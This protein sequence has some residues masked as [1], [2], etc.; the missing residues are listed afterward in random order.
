[1][2]LR[3]WLN[4]K[5]YIKLVEK[6]RE[7]FLDGEYEDALVFYKKAFEYGF[8]IE[9][10][11]A[12]GFIYIELGKLLL[13]EEVFNTVL[14]KKGNSNALYGLGCIA[15]KTGKFEEAIK[16][17]EDSIRLNDS[18]PGVYFDCAYLYDELMKFDKAKEYYLKVIELEDNNFWAHLNIGTI[19]E[20]ENDLVNSLSHYE[21]AYQINNTL[22]M[23]CYNLGV[24]HSKLGNIDLAIRYYKEEVEK[25]D[26]YKNAYFNL[27][28]LYKDHLKDYQLAKEA[29]LKGIEDDKEH[30]PI[31][32]NLGCLYALLKDY[33]NAFDCFLY[34]K[35][36]SPKLFNYINED[37][38]LFEFRKSQEYNDLMK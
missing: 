8:Y 14:E 19:Y 16:L 28:I 17:Y 35:Y 10:L 37:E 18:V 33:K 25:K 5:K 23:I 12:L 24:V 20:Q 11:N 2:S 36:K 27:A 13:A 1:M 15:K 21:I 38:E 34:I 32:Y 6:G 30:Y 7:K 31:W 22:P 9:D 29:Y 3:S 26:R 4:Y